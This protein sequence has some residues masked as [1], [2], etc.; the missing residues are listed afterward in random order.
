[1]NERATAQIFLDGKQ[2][3][4]VI[5][6]LKSRAQKLKEE[7]IAAGQAGDHATMKKLQSE[8]K[9][10]ESTLSSMKKES[11][12]VQKV[13][14]N[15]SAAS[16]NDLNKALGKVNAEMKRMSRTDPGYDKLKSD[17]KKLKAELNGV[18]AEM[19]EQ[20]SLASRIA[21]KF[22]NYFGIVAGGVAA[23]AGMGM[24]V[25]KAIDK[26]NA[27][28]DTMGK[29]KAL[30]DLGKAE[31][32]FLEQQAIQVATTVTKTVDGQE[33]RI[34]KDTDEILTAYQL[35]GSQKPEL[36]ANKEALASVTKEIMIMAE[37]SEGL[38]LSDAIGATTIAMNQYGAAASEAGRY[39]NS[40]A[41]GA[42]VGAVEVPQIGEALKDFAVNAKKAKVPIEGSVALIEVM[43]EKAGLYG[44]QAG[45][46]MRNF[47]SILSAGP[48]ETNPEV[49]GLAAAMDNLAAKNMSSAEWVKVFGRENSNAAQILVQNR[50]YVADMTK[51]IEGNNAAY[52]QAAANTADNNAKLTQ[53]KTKAGEYAVEIGEKLAP[54]QIH[55]ISSGKLL[56]MTIS[57]LIDLF[58]E[59]GAEILLV[60]GAVAA[61]T[62]ALKAKNAESKVSIFLTKSEA[63]AKTAYSTIID[64]ITGKV[65]LA[66]I[67]QKIW[68]AAVKDN[69]IGAFIAV[70]MLAAGAVVLLVKALNS[71]TV[72]Q[73]A[74]K[75]VT[76][77]AKR[78][79]IE[80]KNKTEE[81]LATAK[82]EKK[83]LEERKAALA[84][85]N[86]ISP[87]YF[88]NLSIEKST[89]EQ[90][91]KAGEA[92]IANL[93]KQALVKAAQSKIDKLREENANKE[94]DIETKKK[95]WYES[96]EGA[97]RRANKAI[98]ANKEAITA[99]QDIV[100]KNKP[101]IDVAGK[102]TNDQTTNT[103]TDTSESDK[104]KKAR[105]KAEKQAQ[106]LA[107]A[108][109]NAAIAASE[110]EYERKRMFIEE[111]V[112]DEVDKNKQ[113]EDLEIAKSADTV[114]LLKKRLAT[115]KLTA[116]EKVKLQ[117]E[118]DKE[119]FDLDK[120]LSKQRID[121]KKDN[122]KN[123]IN[124]LEAWL[125]IQ[126][127]L[128]EKDATEKGLSDSETKALLLA[129]DGEF[130][131]KKLAIQQKYGDD[132]IFTEAQIKKN[133]A[134]I[135]ENAAD[136]DAK[137]LKEIA[138]LKKKYADEETANQD[139]KNAALAELNTLFNTDELKKTE[140]YQKLKTKITNKYEKSRYEIAEKYLNAANDVF[141]GISDYQSKKKEAELKKAG[142]DKKKQDAINKKYAKKEQTIAIGQ[143]L[144]A[145]S[146]AVMQ[147]W[148]GWTKTDPV[149]DTI[150]KGILTALAVANTSAQ[151]ATIKAQTF[152][153][154]GFTSPG[155]K[156]DPVGIVHAGEFVASQESVN[157]PSIRPMLNLIDVA[158][159]NGT[160]SRINI[161]H[162]M[163]K[164]YTM[165]Q[166]GYAKGGYTSPS[167]G[168]STM[169]VV[170]QSDPELKALIAQNA[171]LLEHLKQNGVNTPPVNINAHEV[172]TKE[173]DYK[174]N[175]NASTF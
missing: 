65:K 34:Q 170:Q 169:T 52:K 28:E 162:E 77:Q 126:K 71:Q 10:V 27:R 136:G 68:N 102:P 58:K 135:A 49:V 47:F 7:I 43:G 105:E 128:I 157:N 137:R 69:P 70:V 166:I 111:N 13:L 172:W 17:A 14:D 60:A 121:F 29:V 155:D 84:E 56:L 16:I 107:E 3:E 55:L 171:A 164:I 158:Q 127:A 141:N 9:G 67:W 150:L 167:S 59:H 40:M 85:L 51:Q 124:D 140:E 89:T 24:T 160:A 154:G 23:V 134:D 26:A 72:A 130:F 44:P 86:K 42:Q 163:V 36:L 125:V 149:T 109:A 104:E 30:T 93:E 152:S 78:D 25:Q 88:G 129:Q 146:L 79:I 37:A 87:E 175:I 161:P 156:Y 12:N 174:S 8:L 122:Y 62:I 19:R 91:T 116:V 20:Q 120:K 110:R 5:D 98:N 151:V 133:I 118:I 92:Y 64:I 100:D 61:Y 142:D 165:P 147:I 76:E 81:L 15:L 75:D 53:A 90:L 83:S 35:V 117:E 101:V 138:E 57:A 159:R 1:M 96:S 143:A 74:V 123:E 38:D 32:D 115:E 80:Q 18:N 108:K 168:N 119:Q 173:N 132:T 63:I 22:N 94:I 113:L 11:F 46:Q 41:A 112:F 95:K 139:A 2:A 48:K 99:L 131:L 145:G 45:T 21:D 153:K 31:L 73:K 4:A 144:I 39:T 6:T 33:I 114:S 148:K 82:N 106:D 50:Q 66:T 103:T 54:A 97:A